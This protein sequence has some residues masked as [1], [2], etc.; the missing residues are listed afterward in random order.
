MLRPGLEAKF[1]CEAAESVGA[2]LHFVGA[3][4]NSS[5]WTRLH[6]ETRFN[7]P[8]YIMKRFQYHSSFWSD[9]LASNRQ[10]MAIAGP[11]AFTEECL[12]IQS[13]DVFFPKFKKIFVDEKDNEL[14]EQI[15]KSKGKKIVV[16]VNQWHMEGIEHN[17]CHRY[18][19][20]PRSVEFPEGINPIGDMNLRDGLFQRLYN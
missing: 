18:G 16:L 17:W 20:L 12:D 14:F 7:L 5:T 8:E 19:Q 1:A 2:N 9:E 3:E 10:K 11:R 6:H 13:T 15:D 4:L